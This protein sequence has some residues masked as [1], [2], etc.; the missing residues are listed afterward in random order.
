MPPSV[1]TDRIDKL[2][3]KSE[4]QWI[5]DSRGAGCDGSSIWR[6]RATAGP[7]RDDP[8]IAIRFTIIALQWLFGS[9]RRGNLRSWTYPRG[10]NTK[11]SRTVRIMNIKACGIMV[12]LRSLI[13]LQLISIAGTSLAQTP[14]TS[15]KD[16]LVGHWQLVSIIINGA[17]PYGPNPRGSM[18]L[19][20]SGHY[21]VIVLSAGNAKSISYFGTYTV[22]DADSSMTM[23]VDAS[24]RLIADEPDA[25]RLVNFSGGEMTQ[26]TSPSTGRRNSIKVTWKR[27]D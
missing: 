11:E 27:S 2:F 12:C 10:M 16:Q 26:E 4:T 9:T 20:A 3:F 15:I 6:A 24:S 25:K 5:Y 21:L 19:D 8:R 7:W 18:F 1:R 17:A 22:N 13:I 23:R 14:G